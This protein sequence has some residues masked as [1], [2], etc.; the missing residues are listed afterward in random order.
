MVEANQVRLLFIYKEGLPV[1]EYLER[2]PQPLTVPYDLCTS[3][4]AYDAL[5]D[6]Y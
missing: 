6:K 3:Q 5:P 2:M 4:E 1:V